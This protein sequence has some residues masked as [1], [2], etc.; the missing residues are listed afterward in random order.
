MT[1]YATAN[2][3]ALDTDIVR[4]RTSVAPPFSR[5]EQS[6]YGSTRRNRQLRRPCIATN[7]H[8]CLFC[9]RIESFQRERNCSRLA[10]SGSRQNSPRQRVLTRSMSNQRI[11]AKMIPEL[12]RQGA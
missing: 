4:V 1:I 3:V 2:V 8:L 5:A 11:Q 7:V 6:N 10:G 12:V 9:Q